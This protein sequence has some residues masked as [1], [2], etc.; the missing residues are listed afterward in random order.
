[1]CLKDLFTTAVY[2]VVSLN[3]YLFLSSSSEISHSG[4][5]IIV[6]FH[7]FVLY[8]WLAPPP[9]CPLIIVPLILLQSL[10][11]FGP[12]LL[13]MLSSSS[14]SQVLTMSCLRPFSVACTMQD[15]LFSK[16]PT[17][18]ILTAYR[19]CVLFLEIIR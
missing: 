9:P 1:M 11:V 4:P 7:A 2:L 6:K 16:D 18:Q 13:C 10:L 5:C 3:P 17:M 19:K 8:F 15:S 12:M 14:G